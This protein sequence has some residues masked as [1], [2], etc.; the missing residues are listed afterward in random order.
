MIW[1][2]IKII[3]FIGLIAAITY[4]AGIVM[5]TG[6][7]ITMQF[8]GQE[9]AITP[10]Q[11][12]I[13]LVA[14]VFVLW[15]LQWV[16]GILVATFKFF[17]GD[18]T[19]ISRYFGRNK[20]ER[21]YKALAEGMV[22]LA[23]GEGKEAIDKAATAER[24]L[25]RPQLTNLVSAQA[26][27]A[28]GDTRRALKYYK[29][30]LQDDQTRFV[31]VQGLMKQ[32]LT[33]GD[34]D[35]ALALAEKAFA[36]RPGHDET[37]TALFDLQ[38]EKSEWKGAQKTIEAKV[39]AG[40]LPKD[41]GRRREAI[42]GLADARQMLDAGDIEGGQTAAIAANKASPDLIPA[43]VLAA[44]MHMLNENKRAA[45]NALK[46]AWA[47]QPHPDLAAAFAEIAP[48]ENSATRLKRFTALT[49]VAV[50][51]AETKL[52]KA[53]LALADED[54]PAARRAARELAENEPTV[55]SLT[56]M[57]AIEKGEGADDKTVRAWLNKALNAPR[58]PQWVCDSC[59]NIHTG[60]QPRCENCETFDSLSWKTPPAG[61]QP[62]SAAMLGFTAG[63]LTGDANA[64]K[65]TVVE[66]AE[67]V[68]A[69]A[70]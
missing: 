25:K 61:E 7:S 20:E 35:T 55:R 57:A 52:L 51:S 5:D 43:A 46:K 1:S 29:R 44:E 23:A 17:N 66:D 56:I 54:F 48:D 21:G 40:K 19:A 38:T 15:L 28:S 64:P 18:E 10:I 58:G 12:I 42:L 59:S 31:G 36:L 53:E 39:R 34:T 65:A 8:G 27:E 24:L 4:G 16:F 49:K 13:A 70:N 26:A 67:I 22:A 47:T 3:L 45:T 41:V 11:A 6:G 14:L 62:A 50:E 69:V 63:M 30:L 68:E 2:V 32:K 37:M 60:W 9:V 33:E